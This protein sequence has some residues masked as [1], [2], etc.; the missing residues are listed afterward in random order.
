MTSRGN[1][2]VDKRTNTL[3][4]QDVDNKLAEIRA[5]IKKL[6]IPMRQVEIATQIVTADNTLEKALGVRFGGA[7]NAGIGHR[8]L[9]VA[10][11][12]PR[13]RAVGD[14]VN[15]NGQSVVPPS[16]AGVS[17]GVYNQAQPNI[18]N[19]DGLFSD[20][21]AISSA[22]SGYGLAQIP[23]AKLGL[24]LAKLPNGTLL[25]LELQAL[26][27]EA[28]T[29]TIARP[30]LITMDQ[31]KATVE[32]GF[33]IPYL[34]AT[35]SG[36]AS[37]SYKTAALKLAVTPHITPDDRV[38]MDLE[39]SNDTQ[40]TSVAAGPV[41]NTNRIQTKVLVDNG[42]TVVLGGVLNIK[43]T[44]VMSKVPFFGDLPILGGLFRNKYAQRTPK[45]LIIFLT[46]KIIRSNY[47]E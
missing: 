36:A 28:K 5:L 15:Q 8:R 14:Y 32:Q 29:H 41:V 25:D 38:S 24:A 33:D 45:E 39:I 21:G 23:A 2:S 7:A 20:L 37:V 47:E 34:Q 27:Y 19:V 22:T 13:A 16:M 42:E 44:K 17:P 4:V 3:L 46:P 18:S 6:D 26:E 40:G 1:V 30:K 43:D 12:A 31:T 10:S 9:G 35:S 11:S